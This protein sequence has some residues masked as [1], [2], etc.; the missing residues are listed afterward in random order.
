PDSVATADGALVEPLAVG[1]HAV[2]AA[3]PLAG[4]SALVVGAGPVGLAIALWARFFG[5]REVIVS[6][7]VAGRRELAAR[8]GATG[9]LDPGREEVAG[10]FERLAGGAP[11]GGLA[12]GGRPG[13][14]RE[15]VRWG[16][17]RAPPG[18]ATVPA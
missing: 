6:D 5:A 3:E 17:A 2:R 18:A 9:A 8:V 14:V 11:G 4:Q 12:G 1:L 16:A 13:G 15:R 7:P 10:A